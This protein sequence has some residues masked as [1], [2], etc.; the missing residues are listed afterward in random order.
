MK[1]VIPSRGVLPLSDQATSLNI[2]LKEFLS[3]SLTR[4]FLIHFLPHHAFESLKR[5]IF[6]PL[7]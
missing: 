2:K 6:G 7:L 3:L 4:I 5:L 1:L